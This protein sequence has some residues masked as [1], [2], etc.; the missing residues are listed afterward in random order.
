MTKILVVGGG[1]CGMAAALKL[2]EHVDGI[3]LIEK[4]SQLGGLASSFKHDRYWIP[5]HY[6]HV[7]S[8]YSTTIG[9]LKRY[10]MYERMG[11]KRIKMGICAENRVWNFTNPIDL[12][13]FSYLSFTARVRYGAFGF[14]ALYLM[15]PSRMEDSINAREWLEKLAGKEVTDKIFVPLYEKNK[16]NYPLEKL[17]AKQ[18]AFRL[19]SDEARGKY[20]YP[21]GGWKKLIDSMEREMEKKGVEII[22]GKAVSKFDWNNRKVKVNRAVYPYDYAVSTIPIP[23]LLS[24]SKGM[25]KTHSERFSKLKYVS[26]IDLVF[27]TDELLS[28]HY[29]LNVFDAHGGTLIQHSNLYDKYPFKVNY[30]SRYGGSD[31]DMGLSDEQIYRKYIGIVKRYF[32]KI[33]IK[34]YYVFRDKYGEIIYDVNYPKYAPKPAEEIKNVFIGGTSVYYPILRTTDSALLVGE[35]IAEKIINKI[36]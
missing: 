27:G 26:A 14:Y 28:E 35:L 32:P 2:A 5:R 19:N 29:W 23:A 1:L 20:S 25:P 24:I 3:T 7:I 15:N 6:H 10:G 33:N 16:F 31:K 9:Y 4:E 18:L 11:W 8:C 12:L 17:L 34:W 36:I 30:F 22:K 21:P 13:R